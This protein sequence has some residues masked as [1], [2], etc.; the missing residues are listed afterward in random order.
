MKTFI[1]RSQVQIC[2][3]SLKLCHILAFQHFK[4]QCIWE[5]QNSILEDYGEITPG[6]KRPHSTMKSNCFAWKSRWWWFFLSV[7]LHFSF[8]FLLSFLVAKTNESALQIQNIYFPILVTIKDTTPS[9]L[10]F[11]GNGVTRY[12]GESDINGPDKQEQ[13][14]L[15][16]AVTVFLCVRY[17]V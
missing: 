6:G 16:G 9:S 10:N 1:S 3:G 13:F 14:N 17:F 11:L 4:I 7:F 8:Y 12:Q 2:L 5:C 15:V